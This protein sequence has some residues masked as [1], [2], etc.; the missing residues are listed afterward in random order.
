M[1]IGDVGEGSE[2]SPFCR[3]AAAIPY[4]VLSIT[5]MSGETFAVCLAESV[6][7]QIAVACSSLSSV[8]VGR[9]GF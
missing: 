3:V 6:R 8:L 1:G 5:L 7:E 2:N 9:Y 4:K